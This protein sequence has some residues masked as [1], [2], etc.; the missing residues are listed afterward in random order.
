MKNLLISFLLTLVWAAPALAADTVVWPLPPNLPVP[1]PTTNTAII[2][3]PRLEWFQEFQQHL[4]ESRKMPVIDLIFDGDSITAA[5]KGAGHEVWAERYGKY[6]VYDM[7]IGGDRTENVLWR[8]Q[9]GQVD[10]LHPK[11]VVLLIGT[12]DSVVNLTPEQI[13][14]GVK[15]VVDDYRKR[16]PDAVILLQ[17]I[18]PRSAHPTDPFRVK[19]EAVNK[20]I[21]QYGDG[22]N[23]IYL[24]FGDKFLQPDGTLT[25]DIMPD[26]LHPS[27]KG[28]E[29]WA[30]A[31]QPIIDKYVQP[32]T[33]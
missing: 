27:A 11:L 23:V 2:P 8:L 21:S 29:I 18:F 12:N 22:K 28:Y 20:I 9:E 16:L 1:S 32:A 10:N 6:N 33:K 31:I 17:G 7:G 13:A 24:D 3:E 15:A 19:V 5:W 4:D 25:A 30:D 26:F 14:A